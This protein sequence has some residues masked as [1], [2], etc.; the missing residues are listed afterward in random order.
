MSDSDISTLELSDILDV[1]MIR[2]IMEDFHRLTGLLGAILDTSGKIIVA[3]GWQDICTR[4][5]R[6]N[7]DT[8]KN[9]IE[10]DTV[11][12]QGVQEGQ[13]KAY[14]C[15]NN[16]WDMVTPL[17]IDDRHM[18]NVF[19][20]Q[21][22]YTD[23]QVDSEFFRNQARR[24]GFDE[25]KYIEAFSKVP[26]FSRETVNEGMR[27]YAR[28][29]GIVSKLCF[30]AI[31]HSRLLDE[32]E[33]SGISIKE[34]EA[35]FRNLFEHS[36]IGMIIAGMDE[37]FDVNLSFCKMLGYDK[38]E[39]KLK[40]WQE[41]SHP[42]DIRPAAEL[43]Q[44]LVEGKTSTGMLEVRYIH[45]NGTIVW[46][47]VSMF[48]QRDEKGGPRF[49]ITEIN[50]I[51]K[52]KQA[53]MATS[54]AQKESLHLLEIAEKSRQ[55]LLSLIEDERIARKEIR[56]LN[57]EL[58]QR[59]TG[60]TA[61][62]QAANKELESFSYSVSHDLRTPLRH[63]TSYSE[64]LMA[65]HSS[66]LSGKAKQYL[67]TINRA[68]ITMGVLIDALLLFARMGKTEMQQRACPMNDVLAK[69]MEQILPDSPEPQI[70]MEIA[71]LPVVYG[72]FNLLVLVWTNLLS[73]A[74]KYSRGK[75][76]QIIK[77]GYTE[78][79]SDYIFF[80]N[81]NGIG[82]DMEYAGNLFGV[83]QRLHS[84]KEFEGTGIG[85]ANVRRIVSRHRG[86]TWA[87]ST[88]GKGATFYFSLPKTAQPES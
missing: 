81:D 70:H 85:L 58:E 40:K 16:M 82:F 55:V 38:R 29:A 64:I 80:I 12:T 34:S 10:S 59:V 79:N 71:S 63:I 13:F 77:V 5:H 1:E 17:M 49:V 25:E 42:D 26:R 86:R 19:I 9:C 61:E 22:F 73:N 20:G 37:S 69:A 44:S 48:L 24:F 41:L 45:K 2:P 46:T 54:T 7:P 21:F 83:F 33:K 32:Q 60:R 75:S 50:D 65:G 53:E 18:G 87:E 52:R 30:A 84:A 15:K 88:P 51:T 62:L 31:Q 11:L 57:E 68:A 27:F 78:G 66:E 36:P 4:F 74:V 76:P 47:E 72:D 3:V 28:L 6:C 67:Q 56:I 39:L 23:E 43:V 8:R 35:K 14:R